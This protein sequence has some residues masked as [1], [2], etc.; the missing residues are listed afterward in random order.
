MTA[1][2]VSISRICCTIP[3]FN[4]FN[5]S[6]SQA[7]SFISQFIKEFIYVSNNHAAF[8]FHR[9]LNSLH[10]KSGGDVKLISK[11]CE[12]DD[13]NLLLLGSQ[14]ALYIGKSR[15]VQSEVTSEDGGERDM[16]LLQSE[17]D[18]TSDFSAFHVGLKFDLRTK[19][20][21]RNAHD[22]S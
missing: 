9:R 11:F 8:S 18:L 12:L 13:F 22:R 7:L 6:D 4:T 21:G 16:N 15:S 20:S 10:G 3:C 2:L 5:L 17:I 14:D 19:S 1:T